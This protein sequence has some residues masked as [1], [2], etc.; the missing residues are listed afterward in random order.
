MQLHYSTA[1]GVFGT[2]GAMIV[3]VTY[4]LAAVAAGRWCRRRPELVEC[5]ARPRHGR[6]DT[7]APIF[8]VA[9]RI[10]PVGMTAGTGSYLAWMV[11]VEGSRYGSAGQTDVDGAP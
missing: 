4:D 5:C 3:Q 10:H 2:S 1:L 8:G 6:I 9:P 11:I 7:A